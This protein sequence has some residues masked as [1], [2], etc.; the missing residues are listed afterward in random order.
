MP[1]SSQRCISL[2]T[3]PIR[4]VKQVSVDENISDTHLCSPS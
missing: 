2:T 1:T 3:Q 4:V